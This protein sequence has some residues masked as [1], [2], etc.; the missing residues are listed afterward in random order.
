[1]QPQ[2]RPLTALMRQALTSLD[3][4][5]VMRQRWLTMAERNTIRA[6][7]NRGLVGW[8]IASRSYSITPAG[9]VALRFPENSPP[10]ETP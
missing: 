2:R 4:F 1:M 5:G 9:R 10:S 8:D 6:L 3:R 7:H